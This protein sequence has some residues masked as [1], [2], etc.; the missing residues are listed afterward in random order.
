MKVVRFPADAVTPER[1]VVAAS[2]ATRTEEYLVSQGGQLQLRRVPWYDAATWPTAT[3]AEAAMRSMGSGRCDDVDCC[4]PSPRAP[5][6]YTSGN[7]PGL[8]YVP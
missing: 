4:D 3:L 8:V 2:Y 1:Y 6:P 7:H 5:T